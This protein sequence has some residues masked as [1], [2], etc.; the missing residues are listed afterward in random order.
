MS[1]KTCVIASA[2]TSESDVRLLDS[3]GGLVARVLHDLIR[4][5][6][7]EHLVVIDAFALSRVRRR[8]AHA[9]LQDRLLLVARALDFVEHLFYSCRRLRV[10]YIRTD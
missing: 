3:T 10:T 1:E 6:A 5:G 4:R 2:H 7:R 9:H 8:R